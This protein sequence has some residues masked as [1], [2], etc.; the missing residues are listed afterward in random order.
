M[1]SCFNLSIFYLFLPYTSLSVGPLIVDCFL[2][3]FADAVNTSKSEIVL[4]LAYLAGFILGCRWDLFLEIIGGTC[5]F[6]WGLPFLG[7]GPN[8]LPNYGH[9]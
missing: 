6:R 5:Q 8:P 7:G 1:F 3:K 9:P 2:R 4:C